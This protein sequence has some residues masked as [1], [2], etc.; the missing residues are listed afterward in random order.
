MELGIRIQSLEGFRILGAVFRIPQEKF[1]AIWIPESKISRIP[2]GPCRVKNKPQ[3]IRAIA[4]TGS[5][6]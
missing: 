3:T 2:E 4:R 5:L 6:S 1:N